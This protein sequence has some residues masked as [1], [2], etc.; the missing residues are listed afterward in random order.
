MGIKYSIILP[1]RNGGDYFKEAVVSILNQSFTNFTL[2]ILDNSSTDGTLEWI[3]SVGDNRIT[4]YPSKDPLSIEQNWGRIKAIPKNEFMTMIGHDDILHPEYLTTM[5]AL[6]QQYPDASLYQTHFNYIDAKGQIIRSCQPM[7]EVQYVHEFLD[8]QMNQTLDST[9]TGYMMRSKDYDSVGGIS[10]DYPKLIFADY[11]LWMKLIAK[12]YKATSQNVSFSYRVHNSTSSLTNGDD[13]Q[14][15]FG[16][17]M[18]FLSQ[19]KTINKDVDTV[20]LKSGKKMILYFCQSLSHRLLKTPLSLRSTSV[21][22]FVNKCKGYAKLL[23]P[24]QS[25]SPL[26]KPGI[27]MAR[28]LDNKPGLVLFSFYK[29]ISDRKK[30]KKFLE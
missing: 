23:I 1:V 12:S 7:A 26:A 27:L 21:A 9:G 22:G 13:Y 2:H 8:C 19:L 4:I 25:F 17:Y 20:I 5:D 11:E 10:A 18:I 14:M 28:L 16:K 24:N 3:Q 6:I 29:R 15:A 30:Q